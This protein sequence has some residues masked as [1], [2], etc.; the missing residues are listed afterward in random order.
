MNMRPE[1]QD[2]PRCF[3]SRLPRRRAGFLTCL[4]IHWLTLNND[5]KH[6]CF[7]LGLRSDFDTRRA[8]LERPG[9]VSSPD[10]VPLDE[11]SSTW[12]DETVVDV[13]ETEDDR[14]RRLSVSQQEHS[15][16]ASHSSVA[17]SPSLDEPSSEDVGESITA[18]STSSMEIESSTGHDL[19]QLQAPEIQ[20]VQLRESSPE[21]RQE[22]GDDNRLGRTEQHD[23]LPGPSAFSSPKQRPRRPENMFTLVPLAARRERDF[24]SSLTPSCG[25]TQKIDENTGKEQI[26]AKTLIHFLVNCGSVDLRL[27]NALTGEVYTS[28]KRATKVGV[29]ASDALRTDQRARLEHVQVRC[30]HCDSPMAPS[31]KLVIPFHH[32]RENGVRETIADYVNCSCLSKRKPRAVRSHV[33][34]RNAPILDHIPRPIANGQGLQHGLGDD[35][36]HRTEP[37]PRL[38]LVIPGEQT[39]WTWEDAFDLI[40]R[41]KN[42]EDFPDDASS[43]RALPLWLEVDLKHSVLPLLTDKLKQEL[44]VREGLQGEDFGSV[45]DLDSVSA[46]QSDTDDNSSVFSR[47][48]KTNLSDGTNTE[49]FGRRQQSNSITINNANYVFKTTTS[50]ASEMDED[51][52]NSSENC[53]TSTCSR[54]RS[55]TSAEV[56]G[57]KTNAETRTRE[58]GAGFVEDRSPPVHPPVATF[59]RNKIRTSADFKRVLA[60]LRLAFPTYLRQQDFQAITAE[61]LNVRIVL[62]LLVV[63]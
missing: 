2:C 14:G 60:A 61:Y 42:I 31:R 25:T 51:D 63:K 58:Q 54:S 5:D 17:A 40:H 16:G 24:F 23:R 48:P 1:E 37:K 50:S 62:T 26:D 57:T 20:H 28:G 39:V 3:P 36:N 38:R 4:L 13:L 9:V 12:S 47:N 45:K 27:E 35:D 7:V 21:P 43:D 15:C 52:N 44:L 11:T 33:A 8:Q 18:V 56:E 55:R 30:S 32:W 29:A 19:F 34:G 46:R 10:V 6:R 53:A 49:D 22:T 41:L 59:V